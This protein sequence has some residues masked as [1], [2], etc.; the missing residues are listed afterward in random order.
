ML[1]SEFEIREIPLHGRFR[2]QL[3]AF[4]NRFDLEFEP[5]L[6]YAVGLYNRD[7]LA[8]C[9]GCSR[10][11]IKCVAV[12]PE[13]QGGGFLAKIV[14][15][16]YLHLKRNGIDDIFVYTKP[17]HRKKFENLG[18]YCITGTNKIVLLESDLNG[19][20]R[21]IDTIKKV[22]PDN[23]PEYGAIVMNANPFTLG[24]QYLAEKASE[25]C[26]H[27]IIFTVKEDCSVFPSEIRLELIRE[28][29]QNLKNITVVEGGDYIIS[30]ASFPA[31]FLKEKTGVA[32]IQA[33]LDL[34]LFCS[35]I[36]GPLKITQRFMGYEPFDPMT[37]EYNALMKT[38]LPS[39]NI[40]PVF[41][42][43]L[44]IDGMAVSASRVRKLL[45]DGNLELVRRLVPGSTL[46]FLQSE[47]AIPVIQKIKQE[48]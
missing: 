23:Q 9:G 35:R 41:I 44:E 30:A 2:I 18:F 46:R 24:H 4:L 22:L 48:Y 6:S 27:L 11:V 38:I 39:F 36:A 5:D 43:R 26:S 21:Y 33:E 31:Y 34:T 14:S 17:E 19:I 25:M 42:P 37:D 16:L 7:E 47:R 28:G 15:H 45:K 13:L 12:Q 40:S 1:V 32:K 10:N 29:V 8:A 20:S 3:E